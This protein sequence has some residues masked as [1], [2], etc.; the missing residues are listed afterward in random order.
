MA[1][2]SGA[3]GSEDLLPSVKARLISG[4]AEIL[5]Q[6]A[7][8]QVTEEDAQSRRFVEKGALEPPYDPE[9]LCVLFEHSSALRPPV[10]SY[11]TNID[12][13]GYRLEPIFDIESEED[14][15][16]ITAALRARTRKADDNAAEGTPV[17]ED[18]EIRAKLQE[19]ADAMLA[20][21]AKLE[22]FFRNCCTDHSFV[23][24]RRKTR[25][26]LE[27]M[28]FGYWEIV[29]NRGGEVSELVY[30][31]GYTVRLL[32]RD[33]KPVTIEMKVRQD[34]LTFT[35][36][37]RR[38]RFRTFVQIVEGETVFFKE[39]GDKRIVSSETGR[40]YPT[41][42]ALIT[43]EPEAV[44][45]TELKHFAIDSPRSPYGV[46]RWIGTLLSV[47]GSRS[48]EEV[49]YSYFDNKSVPPLAILVSGGRVAESSVQ[50]IRDFVQNEIKGKSNFHKILIIEAEPVAGAAVT[51]SSSRMKIELR[52]L[53]G[54][55]HSD[56][57]FQKYDERN[58]DKVGGA[59]RLPRLL[60]G[61]IRD[62]N[63]STAMAALNFAEMQVFNPEREDF[64]WFVNQELFR[65][66]GVR[67]WRFVSK[68]P[69]TRDPV[70]LSEMIR[71]LANANVLIPREGREL[72]EDVFNREFKKLADDWTKQPMPMTLAGITGGVEGYA[73]GTS[74]GEGKEENAEENPA[75][76]LALQALRIRGALEKLEE[77]AFV[78][79]LGKAL[80]WESMPRETIVVSQEKMRE[81]TGA[82]ED[83]GREDQATQEA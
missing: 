16:R 8:N 15:K 66:I 28:G 78:A 33:R 45:A 20:E 72:A 75:V 79:Q 68:A 30:V 46:P 37:K 25:Q 6:V 9:L 24:L 13:F 1:E 71:N 65:D 42:E 26:D 58:I 60:R 59:F 83:A 81:L 49:N 19:L 32:P 57:L 3:K 10:D 38:K 2:E 11:S 50:R 67:Y 52:P 55:Q 41:V 69:V 34:D 31:P 56:A 73:N 27:V 51:E 54:A 29:R 40:R 47:V 82:T 53:T 23:K 44:E 80:G 18:D 70:A 22:T 36:I 5:K 4:S 48:S 62:F 43:E 77:D 17:P 39:F 63:R 12:G 61:D 35:T 21:K 76:K 14:R 74:Q 7:S 64:D